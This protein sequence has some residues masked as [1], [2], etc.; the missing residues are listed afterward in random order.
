MYEKQVLISLVIPVR[1]GEPW[2]D[3][4]LQNILKQ[5]LFHQTEIIVIDSG[6]TDNTLEILNKYPVTV[7]TISAEDFN[8]GVT[9]NYAVN[10]CKGEYV[11]MTV[12]DAHAVDS[13][14]LENLMKGFRVAENVAGVCGQQ[15]V[16]QKRGMNPVDWFRPYSNPT[17]QVYQ[18][19][20]AGDFDKLSPAE[21]KNICSWD[22]VTAMY[23]RNVLRQIPFQ[24][25]TYGEDAVWA[26]EVLRA[27]YAIVYNNEARV[28]HYHNEDQEFTFKRAFTAM[29]LRYKQFG[30]IYPHKTKALKEKLGIIKTIWE[31][32]PLSIKE[33]WNWFLYN[34]TR[35]KAAEKA[36]KL[37][38]TALQS[39]ENE[40]DI[41]HE[42]YCGTPPVPLKQNIN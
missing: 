1:N 24:K 40:L 11:V 42:K 10:F 16:P 26:Q 18:F 7:F 32:E 9:R 34:K 41:I 3:A 30:Y 12:Q 28:Y 15:I 31:A 2:L 21:K 22:N 35:D 37:F 33:K 14:W 19:D 38:T 8:H 13:L 27:G 5:S 29:Y 23:K 4:C 36:Y 20:T 25:I 6:S 39:G 17:L